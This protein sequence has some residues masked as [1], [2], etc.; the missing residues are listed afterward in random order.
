MSINA[1]CISVKNI[2]PSVKYV[3]FLIYKI[4]PFLHISDTIVY[5]LPVNDWISEVF[6]SY[7]FL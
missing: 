5:I 3:I 4:Q 6:Q 1:L 2:R 7:F